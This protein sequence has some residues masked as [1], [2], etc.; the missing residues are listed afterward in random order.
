M[1]DTMLAVLPRV[2]LSAALT[3][4][5]RDGFG[6]VLRVMDPDRASI[7]AQLVRAGIRTSARAASADGSSVVLFVHAPR[8]AERAAAIA[9]AQGAIDVELVHRSLAVT[10]QAP[11]DIVQ[12]AQ[13]RRMRRASRMRIAHP[14]S[15]AET[16]LAAD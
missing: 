13:L 1:P 4:L 12:T 14:I 3:A 2:R 11:V 5:H 6:P 16:G 8:R 7:A 15:E 9:V 10:E